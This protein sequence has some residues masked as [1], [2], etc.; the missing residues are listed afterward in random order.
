MAAEAAGGATAGEKNVKH[1]RVVLGA[2]L[3]ASAM[4]APA[5]YAAPAP[6]NKTRLA[7]VVLVRPWQERDAALLIDSI[8]EFAGDAAT[9]PVY[10]VLSD[11]ANTPGALLR[12][13]GAR[14]INLEM[15]ARFR[16]YPYAD[17]VWACEQ[18]EKLVG[19][20]ADLLVWVFPAS[21]V[22]A[23]LRELDLAP[24]QGA[25]FR[26]VHIQLAGLSFG[27]PPD[28]F[29]AG[30]YKAT[31]LTVDQAFPVETL[32]QGARIHA[33]FNSGFFAVRPQLG[34]M[35]AW[36]ENFEKLLL[37]REFQAKACSDD[38]HKYYL[39]Q[40]VLAAVVARPGR[41]R[42]RLL[43]PTYSYPV[44]LHESVVPQHRAKSANSLVEMSSDYTLRD[45]AWM[46]NLPVEEPLRTWLVKR[47]QGEPLPVAQGVWRVEGSCNSYLVETADGNVL[48]DPG[49]AGGP[50]SKLAGVNAEPVKVVLLTHGHA[51]HVVQVPA[52]R[53]KGVPV[54]AQREYT[55]LQD[56]QRRLSGFLGSRFAIQAGTPAPPFRDAT[57]G[58]GDEAN[59]PS[60]FYSDS[61]TTEVGGVH[62]EAY[63]TGGETPDQSVIWVPE[64]RTVF[65]G[66]NF[67]TSFPNLCTLRGTKP[68]WALDYVKALNKALELH[69]EVL[70]PGHGAPVWG[71]AEVTKQLTRYR[72]A[73][74]Y[75]HD[76]TVRGMNQGKDVY[77]LM[78]EIKL[79]QELAV[80]D[81]FGTVSWSVRGIYESYAGWFDGNPANMYAV[82]VD[83]IYPE[84]VRLAGSE[85]IAR[86]AL[87]LARNGDA[88]AALRLSDVVLSAEPSQSVALTA[89]LTAL[90][91]LRGRSV[92]GIESRWLEH[93][94]Q[95]TE[96]AL[97]S[98]T[99][100]RAK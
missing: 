65:I 80:G 93:N 89:R 19:K 6:A 77:T 3:A 88:P 5:G 62:F 27:A 32:T 48:I 68:R 52:W 97:T 20:E 43:P 94:I 1:T 4:A 8:H 57:G 13:K 30:I 14:V 35:H 54:V 55:E 69:P 9:A 46:E 36:R 59:G 58:S 15:D 11:P 56:Y 42:I 96:A 84:L 25:A 50:E 76:A 40:A 45:P 73:I 99:A 78:R 38:Q 61:Y 47:I 95:T 71:A 49:S 91:A 22:V 75:V 41:D 86:R 79:P 74:L 100:A 7:F 64:R 2:I 85:A 81:S 63:H 87:E 26:P 18:V 37:D 21:L 24:E 60:E 92:N 70:L 39:H 23:P 67:Y 90:K 83:A 28:A 17:K 10:A 44:S 51:D 34:L 29:W 66:D 72:D 12:S 16:D 31:G 98:T 53:A 33:Y 82:P